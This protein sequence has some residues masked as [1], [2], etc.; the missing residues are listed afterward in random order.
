MRKVVKLVREGRLVAEVEVS[1]V[2]AADGWAPY[3]SMADARRL[4]EVRQ[5]LRRGDV[6][7]AGRH[8][9]VYELSPLTA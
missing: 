2:E 8:G 4:D 3:L 7:A 9:H 1:P 5:A 6:R